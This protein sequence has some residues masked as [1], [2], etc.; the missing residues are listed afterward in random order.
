MNITEERDS[1]VN[2]NNYDSVIGRKF[3]LKTDLHKAKVDIS[4]NVI[5]FDDLNLKYGKRKLSNTTIGQKLSKSVNKCYKN[6][7][8]F[9]FFIKLFPIIGWIRTYSIRDYLFNDI[10]AGFTILILHIPQGMAYGML[11]GLS[12]INGLYVSF[13]PVIIYAFMGTSR[14]VSIGKSRQIYFIN[15]HFLINFSFLNDFFSVKLI[16]STLILRLFYEFFIVKKNFIQKK[17]INF[18]LE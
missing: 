6:C 15:K 3:S 11:S 4:R 16:F 1:L 13:F 5:D 9:D 2:S 8:L 12:A 10:I 17:F 14:H 18:Y 7:S